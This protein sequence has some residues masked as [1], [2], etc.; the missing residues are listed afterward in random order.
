MKQ[1]LAVVI[2]LS[3]MPV[4]SQA[5]D[6]GPPGAPEGWKWVVVKD[7]T[8]QFLFPEKFRSLGYESRKF[9]ARGI[10]AEVQVNYGKPQDGIF[11]ELQGATLSGRGV[12][13]LKVDDMYAIML[14]GEKQHGF[15]IGDS[16]ETSLGKYKAREYRMRKDDLRCRSILTVINKRVFEMRVGSLD[17]ADLDNDRANVFLQSLTILKDSPEAESKEDSEKAEERAKEAMEKF[18]FKWTLKLEEMTPPEKPL[19]GLIHGREFRPDSIVLETGGTLRFRQGPLTSP[20]TDVRIVMFSSPKDK[21]ENRGI[22]IKP[23]SNP[24]KAPTIILTTRDPSAR[25][26]TTDSAFDKYA[27]KL[28]FGAKGPDGMIP[29]TIYLCMAD[30]KKSFMAGKFALPAK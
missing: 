20:D 19:I 3:L 17:E 1:Y 25:V 24:G 5:D 7:R 2:V 15:T 9:T 11:F 18:G 23:G 21:F 10:R 16:K 27:M 22:E 26:P 14:E 6:P 4:R 8:Y 28:S 29:C 12:S 13:S 30:K